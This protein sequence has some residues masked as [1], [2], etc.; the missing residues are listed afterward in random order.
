MDPSG[1]QEKVIEIAR[2]LGLDVY[3]GV[4]HEV[5]VRYTGISNHLLDSTYLKRFSISVLN[6]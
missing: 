3:V 6:H 5:S 2:S 4:A 1:A